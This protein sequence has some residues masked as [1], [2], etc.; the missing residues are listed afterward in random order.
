V[1][2]GSANGCDA[3]DTNAAGDKVL[4]PAVPSRVKERHE[5]TAGGIHAREIGTFAEIATVAG[6]REIVNVIA[7]S[8]L[9]GNDVLDVVG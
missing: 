2:S 6:E 4:S 8:V 9:L 7:P 1:Y 3:F 5:L